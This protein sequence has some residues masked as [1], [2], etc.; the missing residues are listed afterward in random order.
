MSQSLQGKLVVA[1][2]SSALFDLTDSDRVFREGGEDAYRAY[3][4]EREDQLLPT[5][6]AFPFIRRLL[7]LNGQDPS[8]RPVEV[9]LLSRND[10]DTG[11][12]VFRSIASHGLEIERAV[13][14]KG[15]APWPYVESFGASLFLSAN[16][17]DV[18]EAIQHGIPAGQV[19]EHGMVHDDPSDPGLRVAFDFDGV[20]ADDA[21]ERIYKSQGIDAFRANEEAR[22]SEPLDPGPLLRLFRDLGAVQAVERARKRQD[23]SYEPRL[24]IAIATARGAPSHQRV[25][26]SLRSWGL[27]VDEAFFLGGIAKKS[28]L[29]TFRPHL[30][31]DDQLAHVEPTS[32]LLPSVHVP[33][34]VANQG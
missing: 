9:V 12:R 18:R 23:P 34:G 4:R 14:T 10:P 8:D 33:F 13:F 29:A 30:F 20:L 16:P 19:L 25:V 1:V 3:Q 28:V 6:V 5:G 27:N 32:E 7:S 21:S 2:A 11:A 17:R 31:F 24:R 22:R 15:K 26:T